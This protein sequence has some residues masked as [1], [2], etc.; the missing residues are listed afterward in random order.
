M[1][2]TSLQGAKKEENNFKLKISVSFSYM[3]LFFPSQVIFLSSNLFSVWGSLFE[4]EFHRVQS[5]A[6]Q[7]K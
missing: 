7:K 5:A 6:F 2:F 3:V 1:Y 4:L